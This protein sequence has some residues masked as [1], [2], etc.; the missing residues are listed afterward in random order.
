MLRMT[1]LDGRLYEEFRV[2]SS[3][4][5]EL[6]FLI[7]Q[8]MEWPLCDTQVIRHYRFKEGCS[9]ALILSSY[10]V[11]TVPRSVRGSRF[12]FRF[13]ML[14]QKYFPQA[15]RAYKVVSSAPWI[16]NYPRSVKHRRDD[17]DFCS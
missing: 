4:F 9:F 14:F 1:N 17:C 13:E 7:L 3:E 16:L 10:P 15:L 6:R 12:P 2:W 5:P 8:L 11:A